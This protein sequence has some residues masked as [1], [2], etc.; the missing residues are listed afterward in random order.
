MVPDSDSPTEGAASVGPRD[1]S[2]LRRFRHVL[3]RLGA[4][5]SARRLEIG[6]LIFLMAM[7]GVTAYIFSQQGDAGKPLTPFVSAVLM[8]LNL[9]PASGLIMLI[10]RR[11]AVRRAAQSAIGSKGRLHVRLVAI[12]SVLSTVPMLLVVIFASVLFQ[13]GI[14]FWFSDTARGMLENA[15]SLARGYY[16]EKLRDVSDE[17]VTMAG[18]LRTYLDQTSIEDPRFAQAYFLQV[19]NRKLSESAIIEIGAD[20]EQ[21]TAAVIA[22][23]TGAA[24]SQIDTDALK[25]LRRGK[26]IVVTATPEKIEAVTRLY[27]DREVYLYS[28]RDFNVPSFQ[29]GTR[30][31]TV[32]NDYEAMV[33]RSRNL[34][35]QFN[36]V[37]FLA[38]LG[39][40]GLSVW[41]ALLVADRLVRPVTMLVHAAQDV[42]EGNLSTRVVEMGDSPD[43]VGILARSFNRMTE[44]LESQT[45]DLVRANAQL[46]SRRNFI[47]TVLGSVSAGVL[48]VD[49]AGII[50][51]ANSK[52]ELVLLGEEGGLVG[53]PLTDFGETLA[54]PAHD[55]GKHGIIQ[56]D[57]AG[58]QRTLAVTSE[59]SGS[60]TVITFED[61]TQQLVD[62][63]RAAWADVARRIAHEI[64]NPL[65]PIQL[66]AERMKRRFAKMEGRDGEIADQLTRTIIRQVGDLRK[67]VDEFSSF[68]RM[69][70]PTFRQES[71]SDMVRH[72]VF[73]QEVAHPDVRFVLTMA[74]PAMEML[75]DRRQLGQAITNILKNAVEAIESRTVS[76]PSFRKQDGAISVQVQHDDEYLLMVFTDNGIGLPP[77]RD[78]LTEPYMTT[79]ETGTGLGLAIV[80]K[81]VDEHF[82]HIDFEDAEGQG[83]RVTMRFRPA[84]LAHGADS[85]ERTIEE[86]IT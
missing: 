2:V 25:K 84:A 48:S 33:E 22:P 85:A 80:K 3:Y 26:A 10:G 29:L 37:L 40:T 49:G 72:A 59:N 81:I 13:S 18:D 47:E 36:L 54:A 57:R 53:R 51:L 56:F 42:A 12:F 45:G 5:R 62:Q 15:G 77:E 76:D 31:Q 69:P 30:A 11:M 8:I 14:Q 52:A 58:E 19:F 50:R 21:R 44:R 24:R 9:L 64:K 46:E 6:C 16:E 73:L 70:R 38:S 17:T 75:C 55:P 7:L 71:L 35:L 86:N 23:Q 20:G 79:R 83:T 74:D 32:L 66:A 61:I 60:G 4:D 43:E 82:G 27:A 78:R 63:R 28:A 1:I 68:A 41:V 39:I 65:T 34:Q 67:I